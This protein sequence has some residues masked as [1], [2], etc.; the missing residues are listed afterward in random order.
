MMNAPLALDLFDPFDE[1]DRMQFSNMVNW[2]ERPMAAALLPKVPQKYRVTVNCAG[3]NPKAIKCEIAGD[4]L[5]VSGKEGGDAKTTGDDH[6]HRSFK[7][8]FRLPKLVERDQ[9]TSFMDNR[10]TLVIDIPY[11]MDES[12]QLDDGLEP[13]VVDLADGHRAASLN[14]ALPVQH[15]DPKHVQVTAKDRDIIV[16]AHDKSETPTS[17]SSVSFYRRCTMPENADL[18]DMKCVAEGNRL[19][20]TAPLGDHAL[21]NAHKK[22]PIEQAK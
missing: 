1:L 21:P 4:K 19:V 3:Y 22:I 9:M 10:G 16:R 13:Q 7:R 2:L 14:M 20:I 5:V 8:T 15:V 11:K 6:E 17:S 12:G 18:K